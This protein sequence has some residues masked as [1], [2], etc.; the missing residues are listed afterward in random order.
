MTDNFFA[1]ISKLRLVINT[2]QINASEWLSHKNIQ[3][4]DD[5]SGVKLSRKEGDQQ[6]TYFTSVWTVPVET[7]SW[8]LRVTGIYESDRYID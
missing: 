7:S 8:K 4:D 1:E 6:F 5:S 3:V 2:G